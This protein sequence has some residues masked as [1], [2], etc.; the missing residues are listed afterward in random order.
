[1]LLITNKDVPGIVGQIGTFLGNNQI[2]IAGM[3]LGRDRKG[4]QAKTLIK[5]DSAL[6]EALLKEI[7]QAH[8]ILDAKLIKL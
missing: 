3:T 7:R 4:G 6:S 8:N 5:I 1:M 2:N